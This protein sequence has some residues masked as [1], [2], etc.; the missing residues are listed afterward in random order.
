MIKR[1]DEGWL[2]HHHHF[3]IIIY[4]PLLFLLHLLYHHH[5]SWVMYYSWK[6][7]FQN[8]SDSS[9]QCCT[10]TL[11]LGSDCMADVP[12]PSKDLFDTK[13]A[14]WEDMG[15]IL[16][17]LFPPEPPPNGS[18]GTLP[19]LRSASR[20]SPTSDQKKCEWKK[21]RRCVSGIDDRWGCVNEIDR[22]G[23]RWPTS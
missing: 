5:H 16:K 4:L 9:P 20:K 21:S 17:S 22:V 11:W 14:K 15:N 6:N 7:A 19:S 18:S 12:A 10:F 2:I 13:W 1:K 3:H 8:A 23:C